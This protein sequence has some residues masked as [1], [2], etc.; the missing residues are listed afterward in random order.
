MPRVRMTSHYGAQGEHE[1]VANR[2]EQNM[3]L[4][5]LISYVEE[6]GGRRVADDLFEMPNQ[7]PNHLAAEVERDY[8]NLVHR[9]R[10]VS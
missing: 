10:I 2:D 6:R 9:Y 8:L 4:D 7:V 5:D 1:L 3:D